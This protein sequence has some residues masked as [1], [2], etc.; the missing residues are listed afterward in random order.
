MIAQKNVRGVEKDGSHFTPPQPHFTIMQK[1]LTTL[2]F[3]VLV[4]VQ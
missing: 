2:V 1:G 4:L 3:G